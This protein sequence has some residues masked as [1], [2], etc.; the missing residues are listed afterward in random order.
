MFNFPPFF[1]VKAFWESL[2][3]VLAGLSGMLYVLG[4]IPVEY[5]VGSAALLSW[6]L[7]VLRL[8]GVDPKVFGFSAKS[9]KV[10]AKKSPSKAKG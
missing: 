4:L 10:Q 7:A 9:K 3:L 2:S 5:V 6:F 8:L 1:Y